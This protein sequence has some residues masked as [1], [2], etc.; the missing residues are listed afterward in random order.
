MARA[1]VATERMSA[2]IEGPFVVFLIGARINKPWRVRDWWR[3]AR[4]M[5]PMM[6]ELLR[7]PELGLLAQQ[8]WWSLRGPL[9]VQ[10]WRSAEHLERFANDASLPH[11]QAWLD[12]YRYVDT[13]AGA[14]GI[15]H[16]S[17][18]VRPG[19][20]EVAYVGMPRFGLAE[21]GEHL[22]LRL[23]GERAAARRAGGQ[24]GGD[25]VP[26]KGEH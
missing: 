23:V 25:L 10:Y 6:R 15:W 4:A 11:R 9:L 19:G 20:Y 17:Y 13:S 14:V 26:T 12:F 22:P 5:G 7:R 3:V 1:A 21:A 18:T 8:S 2:R 16:E 24:R